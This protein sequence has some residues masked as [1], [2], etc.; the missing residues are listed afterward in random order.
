M[1]SNAL[2]HVIW[3]TWRDPNDNVAG[4]AKVVVEFPRHIL[5]QNQSWCALLRSFEGRCSLLV[6]ST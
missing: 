4:L 5:R 6:A 3:I 1:C 2:L